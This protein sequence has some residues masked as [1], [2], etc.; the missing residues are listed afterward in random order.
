MCGQHSLTIIGDISDY[1]YN[2]YERNLYNVSIE[3]NDS[4]TLESIVDTNYFV[5]HV[6]KFLVDGDINIQAFRYAENT[7]KGSLCHPATTNCG[8][9]EF[10]P[11]VTNDLLLTADSVYVSLKGSGQGTSCWSWESFYFDRNCHLLECLHYGSPNDTVDL[12]EPNMD[13]FCFVDWYRGADSLVILAHADSTEQN[14]LE[15]RRK[16]GEMF[17]KLLTSYG[18]DTANL[19]VEACTRIHPMFDDEQ[20]ARLESKEE[21]TAARKYNAFLHIKSFRKEPKNTP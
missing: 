21:R 15:L 4:T 20:I 11:V 13:L 5:L 14:P 12:T 3:L 1:C 18:L 16:R 10:K 8:P 2:K 7:L 19:H 17:K 6:P 9:F